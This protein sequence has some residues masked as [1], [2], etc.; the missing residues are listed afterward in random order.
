MRK[1]GLARLY[2]LIDNLIFSALSGGGIA[3]WLHEAPLYVVVL[4][5]VVAAGAIF[6]LIR[7][8][9]YL[10]LKHIVNEL[11][12]V[13]IFTDVSDNILRVLYHDKDKLKSG[14]PYNEVLKSEMV[15]QVYGDLK[16]HDILII[17]KHDSISYW[18]LTTLG[19]RVVSYLE[20]NPQVLHNEG[21]RHK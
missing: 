15:K 9:A 21:S 19:A 5:G 11:V 20:K 7:L 2:G 3:V 16:S 10:Y 8:I 1:W 14:I 4:V 12:N 17:E 6:L 13:G 18:M